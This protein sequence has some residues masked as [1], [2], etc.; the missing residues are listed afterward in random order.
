MI[1]GRRALLPPDTITGQTV[2]CH[3][4]LTVKSH[5]L[6]CALL[7]LLF[8]PR[9]L[10]W[11]QSVPLKVFLNYCEHLNSR[12]LWKWIAVRSSQ[13]WPFFI[14]A[15]WSR[16]V[17]LFWVL[18]GG[19]TLTFLPLFPNNGLPSGQSPLWCFSGSICSSIVSISALLDC[20]R[21]WE[22][23]R[24]SLLYTLWFYDSWTSCQVS[25]SQGV[26]PYQNF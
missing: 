2:K 3:T 26:M 5:I 9:A 12:S 23:R 25:V 10:Q 14:G 24:Q 7:Q 13:W 15:E 16:V 22:W 21:I 11:F 18:S 20:L 19:K 1:F 4:D 8:F 6:S 17:L